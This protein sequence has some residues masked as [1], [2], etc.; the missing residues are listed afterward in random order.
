MI[1]APMALLNELT[2]SV[3][4]SLTH[5]LGLPSEPVNVTANPRSN[6][7]IWDG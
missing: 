2:T 4:P 1:E 5:S 7:P 6:L 3:I